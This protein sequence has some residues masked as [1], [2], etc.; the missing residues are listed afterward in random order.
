MAYVWLSLAVAAD[1]EMN[2]GERER[3]ARFRRSLERILDRL[4]V[5]RARQMVNDW[6]AA[7]DTR[8]AVPPSPP[9]SIPAATTVIPFTPGQPIYVDAWVNGRTRARLVLDTGADSTVIAPGVLDAT[10]AS[11][12]GHTTLLGV[13]GQATVGIHAGRESYRTRDAAVLGRTLS[14]S[15]AASSVRATSASVCDRDMYIFCVF[16]TTPR[17]MSSVVK[18]RASAPS[19]F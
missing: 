6:R 9:A 15:S 17:L 13:T 1:A 18:A 7:W 16:L 14:A 4:E 8:P 2:A 5:A 19:A 10:D 12:A 11:I 3:A